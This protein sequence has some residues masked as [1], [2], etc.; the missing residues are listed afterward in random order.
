MQITVL[1]KKQ[2]G[3]TV[4][5]PSCDKAKLF[6]DIAGTK[7]LTIPTLKSI[8]QLGVDIEYKQEEIVAPV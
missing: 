3:Q 1:V 6:A 8:K 2:Y 5:C 7:T 4:Y